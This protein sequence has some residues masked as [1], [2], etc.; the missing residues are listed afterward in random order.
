VGAERVG[1]MEGRATVWRPRHT[2]E[3][4]YPEPRISKKEGRYFLMEN[5]K[6]EKKW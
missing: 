5:K 1:A 4:K 3:L 2:G 6:K